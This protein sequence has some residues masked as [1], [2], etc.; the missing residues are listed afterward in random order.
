MTDNIETII[1]ASA[2]EVAPVP[3]VSPSMSMSGFNFLTMIKKNKKIIKGILVVGV[4][5]ALFFN[6]NV[7]SVVTSAIEAGA[8][9]SLTLLLSNALD[10][11]VSDVSLVP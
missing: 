7:D 9:S 10:Y 4:G 2:A 5:L 8:G 3:T 6:P 11:F 1:P